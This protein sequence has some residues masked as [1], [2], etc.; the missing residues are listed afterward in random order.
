[1]W[2]G[3]SDGLIRH[4]EGKPDLTFDSRNS[5]LATNRVNDLLVDSNGLL[6]ASTFDDRS[7]QRSGPLALG[8]TLLAFGLMFVQVYRGYNNSPTV[9]GRRLGKE[10][11]SHPDNLYPAM[12]ALL[13]KGDSARL[14]IEPV[15]AQL[16]RSG[17]E[18]GAMSVNK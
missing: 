16:S 18:T 15:A 9:G 13:E 7:S 12:F 17:D 11:E 1:L 8:L 5:G 14:M 2:I 6:W 3:T 4:I 10:I